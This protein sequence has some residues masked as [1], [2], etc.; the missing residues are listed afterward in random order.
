MHI[1]IDSRLIQTAIKFVFKKAYQLSYTN[2][3]S[4]QME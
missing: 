2:S 4:K 1:V 3:D